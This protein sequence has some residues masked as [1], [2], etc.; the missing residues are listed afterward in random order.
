VE[1]VRCHARGCGQLQ[2][3]S[4]L[5]TNRFR[6]SR[7]CRQ[8]GL[9][10]RDIQVGF[11]QR[12]RLDQI[13]VSLKDLKCELHLLRIDVAVKLDPL[14]VTILVGVSN[15]VGQ[16]LVD[17]QSDSTAFLIRQTIDPAQLAHRS[18]GD[19][20][21][22]RIARHTKS[23]MKAHL[24]RQIPPPIRTPDP[25]KG[26]LGLAYNASNPS[27]RHS[28]FRNLVSQSIRFVK[29]PPSSTRNSEIPFR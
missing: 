23:Q 8:A 28:K 20:Q 13:R 26:Q 17:C 21:E 19:S 10:L 16:G 22:A 27:P 3:V 7:C 2:L 29:R 11:V 4:N 12:E 1:F 15:D 14:V 24:C 5:L 9:V 25:F 6:Y 18:A